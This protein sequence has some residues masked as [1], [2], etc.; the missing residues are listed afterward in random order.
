MKKTLIFSVAILF[1]LVL[2]MSAAPTGVVAETKFVTIG[3]GG[4]TGVY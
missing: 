1:G 4:V 2:F 3:T